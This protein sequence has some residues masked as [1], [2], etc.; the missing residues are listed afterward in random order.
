M[1]LGQDKQEEEMDHPT[2][3]TLSK[4]KHQH[5]TAIDIRAEG[6]ASCLVSTLCYQIKLSDKMW[7]YF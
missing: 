3:L 2:T 7:C 6:E 4:E 5:P 1:W